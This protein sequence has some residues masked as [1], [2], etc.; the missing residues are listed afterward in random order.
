[1]EGKHIL[2]EEGF[3]NHHLKD[4]LLFFLNYFLKLCLHL[5]VC[6]YICVHRRAGACGGQKRVAEP[7]GMGS[8][9]VMSHLT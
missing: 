9:A 7:L 1:M 5:G 2:S 6:V 4:L 8:Q 3:M